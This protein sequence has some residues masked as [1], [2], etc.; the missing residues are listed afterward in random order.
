ML[1]LGTDALLPRGHAT[2]HDGQIGDEYPVCERAERGSQAHLRQRAPRCHLPMSES[3]TGLRILLAGSVVLGDGPGYRLLP[4]PSAEPT[5]HVPLGK[6]T[7]SRH[8]DGGQTSS[9][10]RSSPWAA[11]ALLSSGIR[12][13]PSATQVAC[14]KADWK[15]FTHLAG[16]SRPSSSVTNRAL[17]HGIRGCLEFG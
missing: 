12:V 11:Q 16:S 9:S 8:V 3:I 5:N 7:L 2:S 13:S 6:G 10:S 1:P 4:A 15:V 17:P 14:G